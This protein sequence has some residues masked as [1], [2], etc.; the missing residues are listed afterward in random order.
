MKYAIFIAS[1]I[2]VTFL[3][4]LQFEPTVG[5]PFFAL[6]GEKHG[7]PRVGEPASFATLIPALGLSLLA[8]IIGIRAIRLYGGEIGNGLV[9]L[10][11]GFIF[12]AGIIIMELPSETGFTKFEIVQ[13]TLAHSMQLIGMIAIIIGL[14]KIIKV[15]K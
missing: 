15:T 8:A 9:W 3:L 5:Q 10:A 1:I 2:I 6:G 11:A 12:I 13:N 4:L 7:H 14:H